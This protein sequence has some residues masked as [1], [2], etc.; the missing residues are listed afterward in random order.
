MPSLKLEDP[1]SLAGTTLY[2]DPKTIHDWIRP[3]FVYVPPN[4]SLD[5]GAINVVIWLHGWFVGSITQLFKND[6][7]RMRQQVLASSKPVVLLAPYL[8]DG[9]DGDT[10]TPYA[11]GGLKG[12]FGERYLDQVFKVLGDDHAGIRPGKIVIACHSG[13]GEAMRYLVDSLGRYKDQ[14][15]ECWGFDCLY[16]G[17]P[18]PDDANF[19]FDWVASSSKSLVVR[20]ALSTVPQSVKLLLMKRG[21]AD[22]DGD[23]D[24]RNPQ[25][26]DISALDI[27]LSV[28]SA[29]SEDDL[30]D[31]ASLAGMTK[32]PHPPKPGERF[33]Q[34]AAANL[35]KNTGWPKD[36]MAMHYAAAS[37]GLLERLKAAT[38]L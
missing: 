27:K 3:T 31:L 1:A 7:A 35:R 32:P 33:V 4:A 20:Y 5:K 26:S 13:G 37:D 18:T 22:G 28:A 17:K 16:G 14:L 23:G 6:K 25:A 24:R 2:S 8:G 34:K 29:K 9:G 21:L 15:V 10:E 38:F 36:Q 19:W 12:N 11:V 30:M